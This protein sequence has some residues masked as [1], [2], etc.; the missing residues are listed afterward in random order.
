MQK[1]C[2]KSCQALNLRAKCE[3][4][5]KKSK[6]E[7]P[8][9][10]NAPIK[11][12]SPGRVKLTLQKQRLKCRQLE[13]QIEQMKSALENCSESISPQ[14]GEDLTSI[15]SKTNQQNIPPFMQFFWEEQQKYLKCSSPS[16]VRYHP[17]II[18]FCLNLAAKSSS[19]YNDLRYDP[20]TGNG[21]LVLPSSRTLRDYRNYIRPTRGFNPAIINALAK[22][23]ADFQSSERFV[24]ILFDEM[25]VQEDLVWDKYTGELIGF[26]DLGDAEINNATFKNVKQLATHVLVFLVKSIVNPLSSGITSFQLMPIFWKAVCYLENI[27]LR[28]IS[29]TADGASPN[30]KFFRMHKALDGNCPEDIVYRTQNIHTKENRFL[31]F[32]A[33]APHLIKTA[34]NCLSHSGS[35]PATRF[36]WNNGFYILWSHISQLYHD[37]LETGLKLVNKLTSDHINLTPYS[38]MRVRLAAQV[39][40]ETVGNVLNEFGPEETAGTAKFCLMM[41]KFFDCLNVRNRTEHV[42]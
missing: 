7:V 32:F 30:R 15:F 25:K 39:L 18:K 34:R 28:V 10:L 31:Y 38:V 11:F 21:I 42:L 1:Q 19:A 37:D 35:G 9:K 6:L 24:S 2:C 13:H 33:D 40:S 16:S 5:T 23:T 22:K 36:M 20:K 8:A 27:N 4:N 41:D 3:I 17:M 29:A 26:V 12:T 14:L